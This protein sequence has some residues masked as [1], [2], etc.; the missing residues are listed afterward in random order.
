MPSS[1]SQRTPLFFIGHGSPMNALADNSFTQSLKS[2][3]THCPSPKAILC[4]SAHWMTEGSWVT[5]MPKPKTIHDF[6]GFPEELFNVQYP[7]PGSPEIAEHISKTILDPKIHTDNEMW[8]LDHGAWSVLKHIYPEAQIPVL[9]LSL[10]MEMPPEYHFKMGQQLRPLR[11]QG[12]LIVGS[13]NIVHN[14]RVIKWGADPEPYDW[15]IEFDQ[16]SKEKLEARDFRAFVTDFHKSEAGKKSVPTNEHYFPL[17]YVL[18]ASDEND[19]LHFDFEGIQN[20]SISMRTFSLGEMSN[21]R[22]NAST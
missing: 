1:Q 15:A 7:A 22:S 14:L 5:A 3:R 6:Y 8:G 21:R 13:G 10:H 12:I 19:Q 20:A 9:Q 11:D 4:I 2:M 18:G 16:W 17:L